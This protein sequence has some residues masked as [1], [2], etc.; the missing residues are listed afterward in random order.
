VRGVFVTALELL[1][2]SGGGTFFC[3]LR[4]GGGEKNHQK[5]KEPA[6]RKEGKKVKDCNQLFE[7]G[8]NWKEFGGENLRGNP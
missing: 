4:G 2:G 3:L 7:G 1:K 5:P 8:G 6:V